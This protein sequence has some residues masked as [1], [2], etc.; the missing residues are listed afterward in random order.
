V[1]LQQRQ[2]L[3]QA[4]KD[5]ISH[6]QS[7]VGT[8][9]DAAAAL[10]DPALWA[11][12]EGIT[13]SD[14]TKVT[15]TA[16]IAGQA[17]PGTYVVSVTQIAAAQQKTQSGTFT[18][19]Q[20][21]DTLSIQVGSGAA[22]NVALSDGDGV[23]QVA[24]KINATAGIQVTASV[25]SGKLVLDSKLT[26]AA[27]T[28]SVTSALN[29][30]QLA[31]DLGL[32]QTRAAQDASFLVNN[33]TYTSDTNS[34]TAAVPGLT[35]NLL[36]ATTSAVTLTVNAEAAKSAVNSKVQGFVDAYNA[37]VD[38]VHGKLTEDRVQNPQTTLDQQKGMLRGDSLLSSMLTDLRTAVSDTFVGRPTA[39]NELAELGISTGAPVGS[40]ATSADALA[41]KLTFDST[42]LSS[43]LDSGFDDVK[44]VLT[45]LT[46]DYSSEGLAQRIDDRTHPYTTTGGLLDNR[47]TSE[48]SQID[49]LGNR[50]AS[51][52]VTLATREQSLR[53][54][55]SNLEST[56]AKLQQQGSWLSGQLSSLGR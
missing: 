45:N 10:R 29:G 15:A 46:G 3:E 44:A 41:G 20:G 56:L 2:T 27:N 35:L 54:Q 6:V 55:F 1:M 9:R 28:I 48:T 19:V 32:S 11:S 50:M 38:Y 4:R 53:Q 24:D 21:A 26:G 39:T 51:M 40:N 52:D 36:G 8:L 17:K 31:N 23:Q 42:K 7:L 33:S 34:N 30:N 43:L 47:I 5:A 16:T 14:A 25:V 12:P 13:T 18:S 22:A 49:D 37:V